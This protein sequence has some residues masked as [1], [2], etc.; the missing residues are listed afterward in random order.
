MR[1]LTAEEVEREISA[2]D[3]LDLDA[4]KSAMGR[5]LQERT[6][7]QDPVGVSPA[8]DGLSHSGARLWRA[9]VGD[10]GQAQEAGGAVLVRKGAD[11]P[12]ATPR[13]TIRLSAGTRLMREW[14]GSTE[15]VEVIATGFVWRGKTYRT[16]SAVAVAI[17]GTKWSGPK[18]F[19]LR[20]DQSSARSVEMTAPAKIGVS[21]RRL[22][23]KVLG[24]GARPGLQ[25]ARGPAGGL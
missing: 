18:F 9:E 16:L 17:T 11:G 10:Q 5:A 12:P 4:L 20:A 13:E 8:S 14:N 24:G 2:L 6:A 19:G 21:L 22:H 3:T 25:L 1:R 15:V 23:P 7:G